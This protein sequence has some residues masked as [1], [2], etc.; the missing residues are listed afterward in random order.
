[1]QGVGHQL[2]GRVPQ[3][4]DGAD[5]LRS[6]V[7]VVEAVQVSVTY[8]LP[9]DYPL[10]NETIE[11]L[12][13]SRFRMPASEPMDLPATERAIR[14]AED[15]EDITVDS[16]RNHLERTGQPH[17]RTIARIRALN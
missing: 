5:R 6:Q 10:L 12:S 15:G 4:R 11:R 9:N 3:T 8:P 16:R 7:I 1:V 2:E 13:D 17:V 14:A